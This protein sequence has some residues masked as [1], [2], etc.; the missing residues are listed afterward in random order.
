MIDVLRK[1]RSI[2]KFTADRIDDQDLAILEEALLLA[3]TSRN[4]EPC[5]F[6]RVRNKETLKKLSEL[7]AHGS[8]LLAGC[9]TAYVILGDTSKSDVCIEDASIA[10]VTLH[11]TAQYLGLGSCWVQVRLRMHDKD[12]S[13]EA[14]VRSLFGLPE[15]MLVV[16]VVGI[17]HSAEN[18]EQRKASTL[19]REKI[20]VEK[21]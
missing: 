8:A 2:R 21:F 17:G 20:H 10:S 13:S 1:R 6:I 3:P 4:I 19:K 15:N 18:R 14:Y 16:S 5:E 7:K 11:Y 12:S 9:D